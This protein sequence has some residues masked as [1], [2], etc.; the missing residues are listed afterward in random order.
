MFGFLGVVLM[1]LLTKEY[2]S[3]VLFNQVGTFPKKEIGGET[4][5]EYA[6]RKIFGE[7]R[8]V[9]YIEGGFILFAAIG[10]VWI[11]G[12]FRGRARE[13]AAIYGIASLGSIV[14]VSK[15]G[16]EDYIFTVG[17]PFVVILAAY[18]VVRMVDYV[19]KRSSL[20]EKG[21]KYIV[22]VVLI[23]LAIM[24]LAFNIFIGLRY[25]IN[26]LRG[27]YF[28]L[29]ARAVKEIDFYIRA[30][31]EEDEEIISQ[32][33]FAFVSG[34]RL[35]EE[36]SE[37]FIWKIMY[38]NE[39]LVEARGTSDGDVRGASGGN[40]EKADTDSSAGSGADGDD[41]DGARGD[42]REL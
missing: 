37:H 12:R 1:E 13:Y 33:Y 41:T 31:S 18:A 22:K 25:D 11:L 3:N 30:R 15:G 9:L 40:I 21:V 4:A 10:I 19:R 6:L 35:A 17:E 32:P 2:L 36:Y 38:W 29:P 28:E 26:V 7:G 14:F 39:T 42:S 16:T 20:A 34:R 5:L 23:S 27:R 8:E 24:V